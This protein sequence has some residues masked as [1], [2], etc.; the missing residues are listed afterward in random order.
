MRVTPWP[1]LLLTIC[2]VDS[3]ISLDV[4]EPPKHEEIDLCY[5]IVFQTAGLKMHFIC[6]DDRLWNGWNASSM[7]SVTVSDSG[8]RGAG[9]GG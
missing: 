6:G 9:S 7:P 3:L 8:E 1:S 5:R 4:F 2:N